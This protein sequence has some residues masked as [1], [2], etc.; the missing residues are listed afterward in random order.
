MDCLTG[1][2]D[3]IFNGYK[4]PTSTTTAVN[5]SFSGVYQIIFISKFRY[6]FLILEL[7]TILHNT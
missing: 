7:L 6:F 4:I 2:Y 1:E 3:L 5:I